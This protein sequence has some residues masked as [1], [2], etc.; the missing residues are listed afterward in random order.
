MSE[1]PIILVVGATGA[2]G[3]SVVR[4]LLQ[5]GKANTP[6]LQF[7]SLIWPLD[8]YS[9]RATTRNL[10]SG[11]SA[12]LAGFGAEVSPHLCPYLCSS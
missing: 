12:A 5:S 2:Q 10:F 11:G 1:K 9:I 3:G 4:A 6:P 7:F 8:K